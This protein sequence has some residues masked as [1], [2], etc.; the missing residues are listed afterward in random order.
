M[1]NDKIINENLIS[2]NLEV[3]SKAKAIEKL[4]DMLFAEKVI[5]SVS[6]FIES[7]NNRETTMSTYC[8][9]DVAIPHAVSEFV[10]KP[11]FAF[12]RV[13]S[14]S[15]GKEDGPVEFIFLLAIPVQ[16]DADTGSK[17]HIDMM[18][19]IAELA[20]EENV[21]NKWAGAKSKDEILKSFSI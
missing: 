7:V 1:D 19:S 6:G 18:S 16:N 15:W 14:F 8:G 9:F 17:S 4:A 21:R 12:G 10:I 5:S 20:L 3:E 2:L 13:D 11:A